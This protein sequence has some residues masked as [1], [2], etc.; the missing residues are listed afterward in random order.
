MQL[1]LDKCSIRSWRWSD[2]ESLIRYANN[3]NVWITLRDIFPYPYTAE[4]ADSW[5]NFACTSLPETNFAIAVD[6]EAVG[7][8]GYSINSDVFRCSAEIGYW[9]GEDF[10]GRGIATAA[11]K[12]M[13]DYIFAHHDI[14]RIHAQVFESNKASI[15]VLEKAGY[16]LEARLK[17]SVIKNNVIMD[18]FVYVKFKE[19]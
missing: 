19:G 12:A 7:G 18:H 4:N 15:S 1:D 2:K 6:D 11:V 13:T 9:L 16:T 10:W 17:K 14:C 5:L 3:W 8:I